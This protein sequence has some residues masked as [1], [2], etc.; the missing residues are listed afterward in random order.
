ME[1]IK[2]VVGLLNEQAPANHFLA[3]INPKEANLLK[4][5]GGSGRMT[6]HGIISYEDDYGWSG[7]STGEVES[8][9]GWNDSDWGTDMSSSPN[10]NTT[11]TWDD[12]GDDDKA[13]SYVN[14]NQPTTTTQTNNNQE[15]NNSLIANAIKVAKIPYD[16]IKGNVPTSI[17]G[18]LSKGEPNKYAGIT[19]E[20]GI[21]EG[22]FAYDD[23][24]AYLVGEQGLKQ[25]EYET[26]DNETKAYWD[27]VAF[28]DGFRSKDFRDL[29]SGDTD[30][31]NKN[32][33]KP[34]QSNVNQVISYAPYLVSNTEAPQQSMVNDYF[35]NLGN[36]ESL[37]TGLIDSYNTAKN[38]I[39]STLG[40][41]SNKNQFG[42]S[43]T[44]NSPF[45]RNNQT[46]NPF[47]IDYMITRGLI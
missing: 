22:D 39:A 25:G 19:G 6:K 33:T 7:H 43:S 16:L 13:L 10:N 8:N 24:R 40:L 23:V 32:L 17:L 29:Y 36:N 42:Y 35:A 21:G 47:Y 45:T 37:S 12:S 27:Q 14:W 46:G 26:L 44:P 9:S 28:D 2:K 34:E 1:D 31:T 3:Y 4:N 20:D 38:N 30:L 11:T 41:V 18:L 5:A 15:N